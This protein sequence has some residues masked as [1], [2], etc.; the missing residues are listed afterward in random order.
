MRRV[1]DLLRR[2]TVFS[3][4]DRDG[5]WIESLAVSD[6]D[7]VLAPRGDVEAGLIAWCYEHARSVR[8]RLLAAVCD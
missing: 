1:T 2:E 7:V 3:L 5:V 4:Y 8:P 6:C